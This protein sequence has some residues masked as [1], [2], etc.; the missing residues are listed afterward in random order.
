[1]QDEEFYCG[2]CG[3]HKKLSALHEDTSGRRP[4]CKS[5]FANML[6]CKQRK[7]R[8][9]KLSPQGIDWLVKLSN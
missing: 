6:L 2:A 1:M 5:C 3:K 4:I 8:H 9:R 7:T